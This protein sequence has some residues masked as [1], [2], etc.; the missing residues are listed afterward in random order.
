[1][2]IFSRRLALWSKTIDIVACPKVE[3]DR[4][5]DQA[6]CSFNQLNF[7]RRGASWNGTVHLQRSKQFV[8]L[9]NNAF[10]TDKDVHHKAGPCWQSRR[11]RRHR[12]PARKR[13][14]PRSRSDNREHSIFYPVLPEGAR[15]L[16]SL[17]GFVLPTPANIELRR[18]NDN[19]PC[20]FATCRG[21][22]AG[23]YSCVPF[24]FFQLVFLLLPISTKLGFDLS[25]AHQSLER[26]MCS[27]AFLFHGIQAPV[28]RIE[29]VPMVSAS[30]GKLAIPT[31]TERAGSSVPASRSPQ[32]RRTTS[33]AAAM[34]V[35]GRT[36][37]NSSPPWRTAVSMDRQQSV[38]ICPNPRSVRSPAT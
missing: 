25:R 9:G 36:T 21:C 13:M 31:L 14:K 23:T 37:A 28:R 30:C 7:V 11:S 20:V 35:S 2:H 26:P 24:P 8:I 27:W 17:E 5:C 1:M 33:V 15:G 16:K 38:R 34:L 6:C 29:R 18:Q 22:D 12:P 32:T 4:N 3:F 10:R 19:A